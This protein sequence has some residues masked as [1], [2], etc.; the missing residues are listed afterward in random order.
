[1][2][3]VL[4]AGPGAGWV[5]PASGLEAR[6]IA[7]TREA[8][9][10]EWRRQVDLGSDEHWCGRIDF[11][12]PDLPLVVEVQSERYHSALT[13]QA[14]DVARHTGLE[15][16][17]FTVIEVWDTQLGYA[18]HEVVAAARDP[19]RPEPAAVGVTSS[20]CSQIGCPGP[21]SDGKNTGGAFESRRPR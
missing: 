5:P 8:C 10:G 16:A 4:D 17:G 18:D 21:R 20:F 7:V 3:A 13:D 1:M 6:F 19:A 11:V 12:S 2:R 15:I 14:H 9:L